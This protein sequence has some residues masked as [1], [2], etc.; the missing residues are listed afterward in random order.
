MRFFTP[1][2]CNMKPIGVI[3]ILRLLQRHSPDYIWLDNDRCMSGATGRGRERLVDMIQVSM[4]IG[5][6]KGLAIVLFLGSVGVL[7]LV[8]REY[9]RDSEEC[10]RLYAQVT[11]RRDILDAARN[12]LHALEDAEVQAQDYV[13]TGETVYSE[14][15]GKDVHRFQDESATLELIASGDAAAPFGKQLSAAGTRTIDE[16]AAIV[17]LHDGSGRDPALDRIRKSSAIVYLNEARDCLGRIVEAVGGDEGNTQGTKLGLFAQKRLAEL[18]AV[19]FAV[20]LVQTIF[21]IV[22]K[23]PAA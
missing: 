18:A 4:R 8:V 6:V 16:L 10:S 23:R 21:V 20:V 13:L 15:Y 7:A 1:L 14:A 9:R 12:S 3:R 19:L 2:A 11:K 17:S 22:R 5:I